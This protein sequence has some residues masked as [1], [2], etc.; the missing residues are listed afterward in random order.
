MQRVRVDAS[1]LAAKTDAVNSEAAG[2]MDGIT[3][4]R[5]MDAARG[6]VWLNVQTKDCRGCWLR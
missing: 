4:E 3:R 1:S 5:R 6:I 2:A